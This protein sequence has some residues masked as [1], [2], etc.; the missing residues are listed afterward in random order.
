MVESLAIKL[1]T[2]G[3][4]AEGTDRVILSTAKEGSVPML[5]LSF[6]QRKPIFTFGLL[7]ALAGK[8]IEYVV[9]KPCVYPS[10]VTPPQHKVF[11]RSAS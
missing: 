8:A 7:L 1:A 11:G 3:V 2:G 6:T 9:H 10:H 5:L 4:P